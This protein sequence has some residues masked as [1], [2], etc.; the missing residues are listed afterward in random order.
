MDNRIIAGLLMIPLTLNISC[1]TAPKS[2]L[3][4]GVIGGVAGAGIGQAHTQDSAGTAVGALVGA[5]VGSL[6]GYLSHSSKEKKTGTPSAQ[7]QDVD[8]PPSLTRPKVRSYM[9]PDSIEGNKYIKSH[10]VYIL[11]D[12]GSW[13][14]D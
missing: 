2:I 10:K 9:V 3:L 8:L 7:S 1:S 5:G 11:E 13:S 14:K 12:P 6:L 4:G